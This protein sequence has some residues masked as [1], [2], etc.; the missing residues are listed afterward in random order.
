MPEQ[1][2]IELVARDGFAQHYTAFGISAKGILL[3]I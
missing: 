1:R 2:V 3:M